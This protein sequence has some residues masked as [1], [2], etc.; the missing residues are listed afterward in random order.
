M[1]DSTTKKKKKKKNGAGGGVPSYL[2]GDTGQG[3]T[4]LRVSLDVPAL[5]KWI[6]QQS[7]LT[8]LLVKEGGFLKASDIPRLASFLT[9]S[10]FGFG[11][12]NPTFLL[13]FQNN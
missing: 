7:V 9:V 12:S 10:Q 11:Q 3:T 4:A 1:S 8:S 2:A 5:T 6:T 13:T